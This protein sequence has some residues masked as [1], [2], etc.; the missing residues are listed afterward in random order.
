MTA[1]F[2][3]RENDHMFPRFAVTSLGLAAVL[4][5]GCSKSGQAGQAPPST[6]S[7]PN[8]KD[9]TSALPAPVSGSPASG[10]DIDL[11]RQAV[12]D[13]VRND[14]GISMSAMDMSVDSVSVNGDQAQANATFR[15]KQGGASMAMVYSLQR[16]GK[17][18]LVVNG[19]PSDGQFVHPP[20][21]KTHSGMSTSPS[22]PAMPDVH[23]FL[24]K[25]PAANSN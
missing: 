18:W 20:M 3:L 19:Q 13:H 5:A 7:A 1:S 11:I 2:D 17:G 24:E 15:V 4:A 8:A 22:V 14:R 6:A 9:S 16:S 12:E 10:R 23:D 25:H 21:D